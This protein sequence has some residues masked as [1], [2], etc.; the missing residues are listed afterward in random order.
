MSQRDEYPPGVPCWID[1][2]QPDPDAAGAFY[3][4]LFGWELV[5]PGAMPGDAQGRYLVARLRDRDVAGVGSQ[6]EGAPAVPSWTMYVSV[7]SADD[8]AAKAQGAGGAVLAEPFDVPPAGRMAVLADPTGAPFC[9]WEPGQRKGAQ[10]VSEPGAWAISQL[11][12]PDPDRAAAFYGAL[13][14]W[15]TETFGAGEGA[16]TMFRLPGYVGGEPEQPVSRE[17]VATMGGGE[18][19]SQWTAG[20]WDADVDATAAKA[21]ELGGSVVAP[22][23]DS[24]VSRTAVIAD[25]HGI[26]F[27]ISNVPGQKGSR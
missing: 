10:L 8:A 5:G 16:V 7:Q 23:V 27:S 21:V 25:P 1:T 22:P 26:V 3:A 15:T 20:F 11:T 14:G 9:A 12:T 24:P 18:G 17:V 13:F 6:V 19:P 2:L 4:A